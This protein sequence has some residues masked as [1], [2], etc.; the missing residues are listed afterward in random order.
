MFKY[1]I[2]AILLI[3]NACADDGAKMEEPV[4]KAADDAKADTADKAKA[5]AT[6]A[7]AEAKSKAAPAKKEMAKKASTKAT[8][9]PSGDV[10][11][12]FTCTQGELTRKVEVVYDTAGEKVPCRVAYTRDQE[13]T[14]DLWNAQTEEGFC[15]SKAAIMNQRFTNAGYT[16]E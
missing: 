14:K 8:A 16:C 6:D 7:K 15:E 13:A 10:A 2:L 11:N 5:K 9:T 1:F 12:P 3:P 4:A